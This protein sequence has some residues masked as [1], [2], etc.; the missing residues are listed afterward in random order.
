MLHYASCCL[1]HLSLRGIVLKCFLRR[2]FSKGTDPHVALQYFGDRN[3]SSYG[4]SVLMSRA[5]PRAS[6]GVFLDAPVEDMSDS[7]SYARTG[8]TGPGLCT[9]FKNPNSPLERS[10]VR[11]PFRESSEFFSKGSGD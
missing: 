11:Q 3:E 7:G 2:V 8:L 1:Y 10:G 5:R 9:A 6:V 4:A